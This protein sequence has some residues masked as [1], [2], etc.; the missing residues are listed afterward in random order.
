ML[1]ALLALLT[2]CPKPVPVAAEP[3]PCVEPAPP[4]PGAPL[5]DLQERIGVLLGRAQD[6]DQQQR[7]I[8]LQDLLLAQYTRPPEDQQAVQRYAEQILDIENRSLPVELE[9]ILPIDIQPVAPEELPTIKPDEQ[10]KAAMEAIDA[11][12]LEEAIGLLQSMQWPETV[13]MREAATRSLLTGVSERVEKMRERRSVETLKAAAR[14][15]EEMI[16]RFP[17]AE[18]TPKLREQ[19]EE[20]E[21]EIK[22]M[23]G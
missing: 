4:A 6:G 11:G 3:V 19:L 5:A 20:V 15:L 1:L 14:L 18:L 23:G 7:L 2:G 13:E 21:A 22:V 16:G 17:E 8:A 10:I 9:V 12:R